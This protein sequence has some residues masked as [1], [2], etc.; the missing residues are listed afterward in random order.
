MGFWMINLHLQHD[1]LDREVLLQKLRPEFKLKYGINSREHPHLM[2]ISYMRRVCICICKYI[3]LLQLLICSYLHIM[4]HMHIL[5]CSYVCIILL[6]KQ[7]FFST[8]QVRN[9]KTM[10][11]ILSRLIALTPYIKVL[12]SLLVRFSFYHFM[13]HAL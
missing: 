2:A 7:K 11:E 13:L 5:T 12:L 3:L 4:M 1:Y 8:T 6:M 10:Y 9:H